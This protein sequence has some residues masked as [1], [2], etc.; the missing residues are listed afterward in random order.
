MPDESQS[1]SRQSSGQRSSDS[2]QLPPIRKDAAGA[3][4]GAVVG[5]VAGPVGAV[6]GGV[7]GA[8][9]ARAAGRK[10]G[11]GS[12]SGKRSQPSHG[13]SLKVAKSARKA[14]GAKKSS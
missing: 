12:R 7:V 1:Q 3:A 11:A 13:K 6:V 5:S 14:N 2:I 8:L 4:A 9:A 10:A